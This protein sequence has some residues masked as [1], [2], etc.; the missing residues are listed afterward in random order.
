MAKK[1][2][3]KQILRFGKW[4]HPHAPGG[5]LEVT[6]EFGEKLIKNFTRTPFAP[7]YRGHQD[8]DKAA[9]N[10]YLIVNKNINSLALE[11]DGVYC[12]ME[13]E[14]KELE[15]YND[16]SA[17]LALQYTDKETGENLGPVLKHV[18]LVPNP[19][20]KGLKPFI[21]LGEED[22]NILVV[23]LS[24]MTD[25]KKVTKSEE[26]LK[27]EEETV[28][29]TVEP[30]DKP[31]E[32]KP[33]KSEPGEDSEPKEKET[34]PEDE[35]DEPE[36]EDVA[37]LKET[38]SKMKVQLEE[39]EAKERK[40]RAEGVYQKYLLQGKLKPTMKETVVQLASLET[41]TV[42][43]ADGEKASVSTL[44]KKLIKQLPVWV[45]LE[46]HGID[47][48]SGIQLGDIPAEEV[49]RHRQM[50]KV[51]LGKE[52]SEDDFQEYLERN[53]ESI[54]KNLKKKK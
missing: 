53:K 1:K 41:N 13:V 47:A 26:E 17:R 24:D 44:I 45:N 49:E 28:E 52:F 11:E 10:P 7:I 25:E 4:I 36:E 51:D 20:I 18:A 21:A 43:L 6:K 54:L 46:E 2:F 22:K 34:D 16:I 23:N 30:S 32:E 38:V 37:E 40:T 19:H 9:E 35:E 8:D 5:V 42:D 29:E 50:Q 3:K 31:S 15:K 33:T 14:P 39:M 12:E 48:E 27:Q